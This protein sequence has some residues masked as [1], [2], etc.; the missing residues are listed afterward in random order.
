MRYKEARQVTIRLSGYSAFSNV[1]I[2]P[3]EPVSYRLFQ[4]LPR[5]I[6]ENAHWCLLCKEME[7]RAVLTALSQSNREYI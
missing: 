7:L 4:T 6:A 3:R 1:Q 5:R 2:S